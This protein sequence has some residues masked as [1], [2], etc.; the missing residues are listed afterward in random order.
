MGIISTLK[1]A[2]GMK[3]KSVSPGELSSKPEFKRDVE[4]NVQERQERG[5]RY[6]KII[7]QKIIKPIAGKYSQIKPRLS[8][9]EETAGTTAIAQQVAQ[10]V[11]TRIPTAYQGKKGYTSRGRARGASGKYIIPGKGAV[12][13]FEYRKWLTYQRRM[14]QMQQTQQLSEQ[15]QQYQQQRYNYPQQQS[16]PQPQQQ[17]PINRAVMPQETQNYPQPIP[18]QPPQNSADISPRPFLPFGDFNAMKITMPKAGEQAPPVNMFK[19]TFPIEKPVG[20]PGGDWYTEADPF[21][22]QQILKRRNQM[23]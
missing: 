22:G 8:K 21:S 12:G 1:A 16:Y 20:N 23:Y 13:V 15:P 17:M 3:A 9:Y 14:A 4:R 2:A 10:M 19:Q 18:K 5:E 6:K 7:Q 11:G